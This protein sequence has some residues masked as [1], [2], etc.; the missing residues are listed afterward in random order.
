MD[1]LDYRISGGALALQALLVE[2]DDLDAEILTT[3]AGMNEECAIHFT[4][5]RTLFEATRIVE[6]AKFDLY[7]VDF[8]LDEGSSLKLLASLEQAGARPIVLSNLSSGDVESYR[9][10]Y[11]AVRFLS[12]GDCSPTRINALVRDALHARTRQDSALEAATE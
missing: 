1:G 10:N 5:A 6:R 9:L 3:M 11:G 2:D 12:K 4:R 8:R 7:F